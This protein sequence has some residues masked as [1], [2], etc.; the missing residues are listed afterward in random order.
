M[1][2]IGPSYVSS[3]PNVA[4]GRCVN[5]FVETTE[6]KSG[7]VPAFLK[8]TPGLT[9]KFLLEVGEWRGALTFREY[10]YCVVGAY[11]YRVAEDLT[12]TFLGAIGTTNGPVGMAT[13]GAQVLIVDGSSGWIIRTATPELFQITD[14]DFP[15]GVTH[16]A[17]LDSYF[18]VAGGNTGYFYHSQV[19]DGESWDGTEF[20]AAEGSPDD[21][22]GL[23]VNQRQLFVIGTETTEIWVTSTNVDFAFERVGSAF[24]EVGCAAPF[25]ICAL[26]TAVFWVARDKNGAG[27]VV[28]CDGYRPQRISDH[29]IERLLAEAVDLES[30]RAYTFQ[31]G[32]HSF[33]VLIWDENT[34]VYD[35]S[36]GFWHEWLSFEHDTGEFLRH[37]VN[38]HVY[39]SGMNLGGDL[40]TGAVYAIDRDERT[41]NGEI[42]RRLR[43]WGPDSVDGRW[44]IYNEL[45]IL[46]QAG[47]GLATGQGE[48]PLVMLRH[49]NDGGHTWSNQI[50]MDLGIMGAYM[51]RA[52]KMMLG[53]ARERVWEIA[54][55][56]P[57]LCNIIG[58]RQRVERGK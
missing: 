57:V 22:V 35:V 14:V 6:G 46:I 12:W 55:T 38:G 45:E 42:V 4:S 36:T 15:A 54:V 56:D 41:D 2:I 11:V 19:L 33:Y 31:Q 10:M 27:L 51:A 28:R 1:P 3:S 47:V 53:R 30:A 44:F 29:Y 40:E 13:N 21:V 39:F 34:F 8:P 49:S 18:V 7:R 16:A 23:I 58:E 5:W 43:Q 24:I 52:R 9:I 48:Q 50:E 26:D 20:A 17:Y 37:R 32:G 25:S